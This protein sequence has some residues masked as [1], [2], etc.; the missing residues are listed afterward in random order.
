MAKGYR[1]GKFGNGEAGVRHRLDENDWGTKR[2]FVGSGIS[3]YYF[4][5]PSGGLLIIRANTYAEAAVIASARGAKRYRK[6]N[7]K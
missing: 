6:A 2:E 5:N 7:R 4:R 3:S 1:G